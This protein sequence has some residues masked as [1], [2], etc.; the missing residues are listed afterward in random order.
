[1]EIE[2]K[3]VHGL[4]KTKY[5][6]I[7]TVKELEEGENVIKGKAK[8]GIVQERDIFEYVGMVISKSEN[9]KD[10]TIQ[11]KRKYEV[12]NRE[13]SGIREKH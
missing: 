2:K 6:M 12:I 9:F 11:L 8:E 7:N 3:M 13:I 1:M 4:N 5:L 10:D